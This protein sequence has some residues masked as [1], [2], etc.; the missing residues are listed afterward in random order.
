MPN[1]LQVPA[2]YPT[3]PPAIPISESVVDRLLS[4]GVG[5]HNRSNPKFKVLALSL[6]LV[7]P[8]QDWRLPKRSLG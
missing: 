2:V 7:E 6:A 1:I 4:G 8:C 3:R 5:V